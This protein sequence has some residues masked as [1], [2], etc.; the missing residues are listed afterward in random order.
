M[1]SIQRKSL[2]AAVCKSFLPTNPLWYG[3]WVDSPLSRQQCDLLARILLD[4]NFTDQEGDP[5]NA[6]GPAASDGNASERLEE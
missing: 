3:F 4:D 2:Q 1:E 6:G 5:G